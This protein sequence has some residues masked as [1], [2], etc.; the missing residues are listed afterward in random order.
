[1]LN[2]IKGIGY[3]E[4]LNVLGNIGEISYLKNSVVLVDENGDL[5][6]ANLDEITFLEEI[7]ELGEDVIYD[8]D[9]LENSWG[10]KWEV[11][12]Q[13]DKQKVTFYL[14]DNKLNRV[15]K[16]KAIELEEFSSLSE[17]VSLVGNLYELKSDIPVV[18]FNINIVK[19]FNGDY[20]TYF[21]AC[22]NKEKNQIDLIKVVFV[23]T[24]LLEEEDYSRRTLSHDVYLDSIDAGTLKEVSP[25]ELQNYAMGV[26]D[27]ATSNKTIDF[28]DYDELHDLTEDFEEEEKEEEDNEPW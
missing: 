14:L 15:E 6:E 9:V 25:Q 26:M 17:L 8:H 4:K 5:H 19:D 11:E 22:N 23:G 28:N 13:E 10:K 3:S 20:Y 18:D 2:K 24:Y 12:L 1:M 27:G 16:G 21:Y 7:G